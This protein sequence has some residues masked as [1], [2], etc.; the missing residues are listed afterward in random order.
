LKPAWL[1]RP[2]PAALLLVSLWLIWRLVALHGT[3]VPP[4][5]VHDESSYLLGADTFAHGRLANPPHPLAKFFES[6]HI[7]VRPVYA[8]KYPP[9]QAMFLALGQKLLGEPFYGVLIGNVLMLFSICVMLYAWVPAPWA[10]AVSAM[11]GLCLSPRMYWT[12]SFWGGS[13]AAGG[14]ALVLLSVGLYRT[15]PSIL[16]GITFSVGALLL[17][18]TRPYEGFVF[19]VAVLV[20]FAKDLWRQRNLRVF[21]CVLSVLIVGGVLSGSYDRAITGNPFRLPYALHTAQYDTAPAF[22]IQPMYPQ[23]KY[24]NPRLA[25]IHGTDGYEARIYA[26]DRSVTDRLLRNIALAI[27]TYGVWP[28]TAISLVFVVPVVKRDPLARSLRLL[29][30]IFSLGLMLETFHFEHYSAPAWG[31]FAILAAVWAEKAWKLRYG[32]FPIGIPLVI[33]GLSAPV[34]FSLAGHPDSDIGVL[35]GKCRCSSPFGPYWAVRRSVLIQNLSAS[36]RPAL[37]IV[38]YPSSDWRADEEE[39]VY[40]GADI[41]NQR[42][43]FAHD[44][45]EQ[46]NQALLRYYSGRQVYMLTFDPQTGQDHLGPYAASASLD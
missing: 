37:V 17:F 19:T 36:D 41:D 27:L 20:L 18:S 6:P 26:K 22:W 11:I 29:I 44:L 24:S 16:A 39:W 4:P 38:R 12:N 33:L 43:I 5:M 15:K 13:L 21:I 28:L 32:G 9:G 1:N 7:L 14:G 46:E 42:V 45:G 35:P 8:S 2:L 10:I 25:A 23:P 30:G 31:A 3:Q 34:F 40:N